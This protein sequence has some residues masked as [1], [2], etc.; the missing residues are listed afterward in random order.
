MLIGELSR[1]SGV[2]TRSIR[3][4]D[5]QGLLTAHRNANG[6]REFSPSSIESVAQIRS[7]IAA[8]FS[9]DTIREV[10]PCVNGTDVDMCPRVAELVRRTLAGIE[11]AIDDLEE[12]RLRVDALLASQRIAR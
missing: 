1:R 4:Y 7:L 10:L 12:K 9:V 6:Y 2:S 11:T 5:A 8:G 3:Y